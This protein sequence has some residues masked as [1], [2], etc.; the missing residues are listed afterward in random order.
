MLIT[1][2]EV[3]VE[4]DDELQRAA[5]AKVLSAP[6]HAVVVSE[7]SPERLVLAPASGDPLEAIDLAND[8]YERAHPAASSVRLVHVVKRPERL[9]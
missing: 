3:R 6:K 9:R 5:V 7:E 4:L 1:L 2:P 8:I